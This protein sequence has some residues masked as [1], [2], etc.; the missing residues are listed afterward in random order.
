MR[1]KGKIGKIIVDIITQL[2]RNR[3]IAL[4]L[5]RRKFVLA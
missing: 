3:H 2:E 1:Q 4:Y 5:P